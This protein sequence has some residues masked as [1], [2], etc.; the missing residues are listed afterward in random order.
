MLLN[1]G[2]GFLSPKTVKSGDSIVIKDEGIWETSTFL[3]DDGTP[4]QQCNFKVTYKGE[5][6][7]IKFTK[8][9]R[10]SFIAVYGN[11]TTAWIGKQGIITLIPTSNGKQSIW[12][13]PLEVDGNM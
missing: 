4:S 2:S 11:Q 9:S 10:D 7:R 8:A 1:S 12:I 3:K 5:E 6:K 13:Q